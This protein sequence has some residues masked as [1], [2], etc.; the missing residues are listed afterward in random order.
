MSG[1]DYDRHKV[2]SRP[3]S[4]GYGDGGDGALFFAPVAVDA[5]LVRMNGR[6]RRLPH[7]APNS[8]RRL[9]RLAEAA[10]YL[11][12]AADRAGPRTDY[13]Q[14]HTFPQSKLTG[15]DLLDQLFQLAAFKGDSSF[16]SIV[17]DNS[18]EGCSLSRDIHGV[19]Y[20]GLERPNKFY[21]QRRKA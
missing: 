20:V 7:G 1:F 8:V 10:D 15:I 12:Q 2:K 21:R 4:N 6:W 16:V 5:S 19:E 11:H 17:D 14:L 18:V 3:A 13:D 9:Q